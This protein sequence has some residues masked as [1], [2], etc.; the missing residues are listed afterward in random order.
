MFNPGID[1]SK[2]Q[3]A[4]EIPTGF[5]YLWAWFIRLNSTRMS[6]GMGGG[7]LGISEQEIRAFF[8]NRQITPRVWEV[9]LIARLDKVALDSQDKPKPKEQ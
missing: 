3:A 5:D 7:K 4:V 6:T 8:L 2:E 9:E 1:V